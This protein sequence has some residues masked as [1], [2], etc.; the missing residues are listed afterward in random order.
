MLFRSPGRRSAGGAHVGSSASS[1]NSALRS[2]ADSKESTASAKADVSTMRTICL[3]ELDEVFMFDIPGGDRNN[4]PLTYSQ[5]NAPV[6]RA[7]PTASFVTGTNLVV[8]GTP[9]KGVQL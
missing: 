1:K 7:S 5:H 4:T 8:D 2:G 6:F 3:C 9:T